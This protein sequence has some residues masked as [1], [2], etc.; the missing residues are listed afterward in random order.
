MPSVSLTEVTNWLASALSVKSSVAIFVAIASS[1]YFF[2]PWIVVAV[3]SLASNVINGKCLNLYVNKMKRF[4]I[5]FSFIPIYYIVA[6]CLLI[7]KWPILISNKWY[8]L[9]AMYLSIFLYTEFI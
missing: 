9:P 4:N 3:L 2:A 7:M 1:A 6:Y 8:I 5:L